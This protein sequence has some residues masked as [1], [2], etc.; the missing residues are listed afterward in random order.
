VV[1]DTQMAQYMQ[2]STLP[3]GTVFIV[4]GAFLG[5][6]AAIV[7]AWRVVIAWTLHRSVKKAALWQDKVDQKALFRT[8]AAPMYKYSDRESTA[9]FP[10]RGAA[11]GKGPKPQTGNLPAASQSSLFFSPTAGAASNPNRASSY[12]PSG[13]YAAGASAPGN[14]AGMTHIGSGSG[15]RESINMSNLAPQIH[16]YSRARSVGPSPPESPAMTPQYRGLHNHN[17]SSSTLDLGRLPN[18]RAPS[19]V[20][21]EF[22]DEPRNASPYD[23]QARR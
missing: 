12:L 15:I 1:P 22:F 17:L 7:I 14:G 3:N 18:G 6:L 16:G 11:K 19:A 20:L 4:V 5:F 21:D 8:P 23:G 2:V 9:S 13:Y 10:K